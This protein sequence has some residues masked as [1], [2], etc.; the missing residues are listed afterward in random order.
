MEWE[1]PSPGVVDPEVRAHVY[2][3]VSALGGAGADEDGRYVLGDDALACL[4]DLKK[5]LKL[6]DEKANRLDVARCLAEANLVS[7][8]LLKILA[9]WPEDATEDRLKS[10]IALACLELLVPLTWP[11][12]K[13]EVQMTVNHHRHVPYLQLAQ[14]SY[15]RA[16][17]DRE[18]AQV[19]RTAV[20][21]GL[22]S[23]ALPMGERISRDEG[24]IKLLLYFF[25]N[26][27]MIAPPQNLPAEADENDISRS[28]TIEAFHYQE[29][30]ALLLTIASN[31]GEDFNT[32]DAIIMEVLFHLVKGVDIEKLFMDDAQLDATK[33]DELQALLAKEAG[34]HKSYVKNA[35][36]R[37]NRFG[38][39]IWMKRDDARVS[40][41][42]G[43]D[44]L[45]NSQQTLS[46]MDQSKKWNRPK[47]R[48]K[49]A[50][51]LQNHFDIAVPLTGNAKIHLRGFVEEFLDSGF[52]P[53]FSHIRKAIEREADR[54]LDSHAQQFFFLVS[55]FLEAERVR[56]NTKEEADKKNKMSNV[57]EAE[58]FAL[59]ASV[60]NQETF[61]LLNRFMQSQLDSKSWQDVNAGMRCFTQILLTVQ[62]MSESTIYEDREIAENIQNR[63]F[64]EESTHDR[65]ISIL[66]GYKDQGFGYLDAC[67]ELSHVF[68]RMLERYSKE[69]L[70]LQV[71]SRRRARRKK[72]IPESENGPSNDVDDQ[73]S[74]AEDIAE[75]QRVSRERKFDFTRFSAK[76]V[77][78]HCVDTFVSFLRY[79]NDLKTEQLKRAHRF[80]YR[81]AFKHEMSVVLF[82]LDIIAL[83]NKMIKGPEGLGVSNPMYREWDELVRQLIK[84]MIKKLEQRPEL[85]VELLFSKINSTV[86]YLEYGYEKQVISSKSRAPAELEVKGAMTKDEQIGVGVA[87]VIGNKPEAVDWVKDVLYSATIER[88]SWEAEAEA[89]RIQGSAP[90]TGEN[91]DPADGS[92]RAPSII[93]KPDN[94][95]RRIA[96]FK[97]NKLRLLMCLVGFE[98]IGIDD[99][100]DV[101]WIIPSAITS[102]DLK[103]T[104]DILERHR[105]N[106]IMQYGD[107]EPMA[108]EEMLRRKPTVKPRA[109]YDDDSE[110]DGVV[111]NGDEDFL[112]P[113]GGPTNRKSDALEELKK[114]GRK[115]NRLHP[116]QPTEIDEE[117]NEARRKARDQANL[118]KMRKIKSDLYVHDS[119]EEEDEEKDNEFFAREK[120]RRERQSVK[121]LEAL[122]TGNLIGVA[123]A[124]G[125]SGKSK[126]RK[127]QGSGAPKQKKKRITE[128]LSGSEDSASNDSDND[129]EM[130]TTSGASSPPNRRAFETS[131]DEASE[132]PVSSQ[133]MHSSQELK[134]I[135]HA[136][137]AKE[138]HTQPSSPMRVLVRDKVNA[139]QL[140][141]SGE[142]DEDDA[143]VVP[144]AGRRVRAGLLAD[145]DEEE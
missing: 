74:E 32:Q 51:P 14:V 127:T 37:H 106:P 131:E 116:D 5:W 69:N 18:S 68:L 123:E 87:V 114:N 141:V 105:D 46:K 39:M 90:E 19:L 56:R 8:D 135:E 83:F 45:G 120:Q 23:I 117:T 29:V 22:P 138:S 129:E 110:D 124:D 63:I 145:S 25:R 16:I 70:D 115:R 112:F 41:V 75:A 40:T 9:A 27:A 12:E 6:Y 136:E 3:L 96:M 7:G 44:A 47:Q 15:K 125:K 130:I 67:T 97:D 21:I 42:S 2:S 30:L 78:Q 137:E 33:T 101:T 102:H 4:K 143:P 103:E 26:V 1:D 142:D 89:R 84:R 81:V 95:E 144:R 61:I 80:F 108:A 10:K 134:H 76:F 52:N 50:E 104:H 31:M 66:R 72:K 98:R 59:V 65:I 48:R 35:P 77:T 73:D 34:M 140:E 28:A 107:E 93:V 53:L 88:Q 24:I 43:Q 121:V 126:K 122:R 11:I 58:S 49:D 92:P 86:F 99:E 139:M 100:P 109:N 64:Y 55:W 36:T 128:Q 17:L 62:E 118:E 133:H 13:D 20:R 57:F 38:T 111:S 71:R 119:D 82:R 132:T 60:L 113:A 85:A 54:I 79:Y 94:E 91:V